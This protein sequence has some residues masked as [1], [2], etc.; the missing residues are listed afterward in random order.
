MTDAL[1]QQLQSSLGGAYTISRELG[2]GG[3]ARVFVARD[4][5]LGRDVVV[6]V[7]APELS[8]ELST[9]RFGREI[10]LAAGLQE[11]HIVPV[12]TA[13]TTTSGLPFYTMPYVAGESLRA[14]LDRGVIPI[15]EVVGVLRDVATALEHAHERGIVHRDIKPEN[16][17][18]SGRTAVVTDFGIAKALEAS[19]THAP[20]AALTQAGVS[21]GTPAYMA[22]EQAL[23]DIVDARADLYSWGVVAYELLAGRPPFVETSAQRLIVAHVMDQPVAL[24]ALAP[25]APS[26]L[27]ELVMR[28]LAKDAA[29][30][31]QTAAALIAALD[32]AS[33]ISGEVTTTRTDGARAAERIP[34]V[35][36]L[37]FANL[38]SDPENEFLSDGITEEIIYTLGRVEGLRVAGRTSC[39]ALKGQTLDPATV[40]RRLDVHCV[41]D[42]S[43]RRAGDRVRVQAELVSTADGFQLW[44][45]RYDRDLSDVFAVQEEIAGAIVS[46]LRTRIGRGTVRRLASPPTPDAEAYELYLRGRHALA[47]RTTTA[48]FDAVKLL[49]EA[50]AHDPG[51]ARAWAGLADACL[52]APVYAG[53]APGKAWPRA[54]EA[55]ERALAIDPKLVE[56][57]TSLAYGTMLYEWDWASAESSFRRAIEL[58]PSYA[59]AHH[60]YA[61]FLAGRGRL[62]E[63]LREMT[64]A[65]ELDPLSP[66]VRA[67]TA[68]VLALLRRGEDALATIDALMRDD[69]GFAHAY[70]VKGLVLQSVGDHRRAIAAHRKALEI[71][72]FYSFSY[73]A[74]ICA[75]AAVGERDE[76]MRLLAELEER[77]RKE[78][79][80]AFAFAL[81]CTGLG[82]I[83]K[84]L[85]WVERGVQA[86]DEMMAENFLDPLFDPLRGDARYDLVLAKL[87]A[88]RG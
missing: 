85:E 49:E 71:G 2:G 74:L 30:R 48:S 11:P 36:V 66:I 77:A 50:V 70:V 8:Q 79:V 41:V 75:H 54:R 29:H 7:L 35:G 72:G 76:A 12:L 65:H 56:A 1:R 45:G 34:A 61:D 20:G 15:A 80:P 37:P 69:P 14:R 86:R 28:C 16:I 6:K 22:P 24:D 3:M 32:G 19:K 58:N 17:L 31:P 21:L 33:S 51:F 43:L 60:W 38:S 73:S 55:I 26:T 25:A 59:P 87:G 42:G 18:I 47:K 63:S 9:E 53:A 52:T 4:E 39:F 46:E 13:G 81:A 5:Q 84:A 57:L 67:E 88:R 10:R 82:D 62:E 78:H 64:R 83:E 44:S 68:W 40:G 23:G 27:V